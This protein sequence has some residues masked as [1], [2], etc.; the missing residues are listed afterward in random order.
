MKRGFF[1]N[2]NFEAL[3]LLDSRESLRRLKGTNPLELVS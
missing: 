1:I 3:Q 2:N